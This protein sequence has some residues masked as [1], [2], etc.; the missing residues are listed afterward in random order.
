MLW[1]H[2]MGS[3]ARSRAFSLSWGVHYFPEGYNTRHSQS[4]AR[5]TPIWLRFICSAFVIFFF[6][7]GTQWDLLM[8]MLQDPE[9]STPHA[10]RK[11]SSRTALFSFLSTQQC[12]TFIWSQGPDRCLLWSRTTPANENV[13]IPLTVVELWLCGPCIEQHHPYL[14]QVPDLQYRCR[15]FWGWEAAFC[16]ERAPGEDC[17]KCS[18]ENFSNEKP[19]GLGVISGPDEVCQEYLHAARLLSSYIS[20]ETA[21]IYSSVS[22][23]RCTPTA[24]DWQG[25]GQDNLVL[26]VCLTCEIFKSTAKHF[27]DLSSQ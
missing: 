15:S 27:N 13:S 3:A 16:L 23:A 7:S 6:C 17:T 4:H 14:R 5:L 21:L 19:P 12:T 22:V 2:Y 8:L 1:D 24:V 18:D 25:N 20:R 10:L 9:P 11:A 26:V